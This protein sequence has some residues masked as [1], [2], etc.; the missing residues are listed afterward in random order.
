MAQG[1]SLALLLAGPSMS[2][3][4]LLVIGGELGVKKTLAYVVIVVVLSTLAGM[5][6]GGFA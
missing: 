2:L 5:L 4:S 1:P 3:P 6:Y